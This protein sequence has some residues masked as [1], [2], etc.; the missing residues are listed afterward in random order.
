MSNA[1]V[2]YSASPAQRIAI[3]VL[4]VLCST[5]F[6][7]TILVATALL[8]QMQGALS[9][10]QDEISWVMT[11]NIVATAVATPM[12]GWMV[13]RWGRKSVMVWCAGGFAAATVMCGASDSLEALVF[14]RMVQG[15][16]GAPIIP[17]GQTLL[18]DVFPR[19]QHSLVIAIFGM[20]NMIGPVAGPTFGGQIAEAFGWRWGFY[21]VVPVSVL[22]FIG[23]R[24]VLP[25]DPQRSEA[26]LDWIG[27]IALSVAIGALQL[28]FSRGQR[29]DWFQSMEIII[30][31]ALSAIAFYIFIVHSLTA[32]RPFLNLA[33]LRDR[34]YALGLVMVTLYGMLN[35]APMVILPPLLQQHMGFP[36]SLIGAIV[37]WRGIGAAIGFF[38]AMFIERIDPRVTMIVGSTLQV[39]SG[40][41]M[42]T[43]DLTMSPTV[44]MANS[45]IQGIA[46]GVV[47]V[48]MTVIAF[49]TL[50]TEHRAE[51]MAN[52]H[53]LRNL[54]SSLFISI[55][56]AEI[57]RTTGTNYARLGEF[58]SPY[59]KVIA[60][61]WATGSWSFD[62]AADL[63]Q[64]SREI[65]RQSTMIGYTNA[66][67]MYT[68]I[69]LTIIPLCLLARR[70]PAPQAA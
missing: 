43:L 61:P 54:G 36:D 30:A 7:A 46:V 70:R 49:S 39:F 42:M 55:S 63:A 44:L 10:T 59:N 52:F 12:T 62:S 13:A 66:F 15:A 50:P 26:R 68:V 33:L 20:A 56:V 19:R 8:P 60:M 69:S 38:I 41:W 22:A 27:F 40:Y 14:W 16:I 67:L 6:T 64:I 17:L 25:P 4:V 35:F 9:A 53:L 5:G 2:A 11:F 65:G 21:M 23:F 1:D 37:G 18:L 58:I 57:V 48:P 29:L 28:V 34:N 31:A 47:W 24:L 32:R 51:S 3:L 45:C